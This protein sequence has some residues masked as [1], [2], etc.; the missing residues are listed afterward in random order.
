M[1][2]HLV[3]FLAPETLEAER[4]RSICYNIEKVRREKGASVLAIV[5]PEL[6][7]GKT[8]TAINLA[9]TFAQH[10]EIRVLLIDLDFRRPAVRKRLGFVQNNTPGLV[11]MIGRPSLSLKEV[12]VRPAE[13]KFSLLLAGDSP[14]LPHDVLN[15]SRVGEILQ[16]ARQ[17][18]DYVLLD[19]PPLLPASD[20]QRIERW[21]DG[22]V[23][24]VSA[25]KT[26]RKLIEEALR[27]VDQSKLIGLI[28]NNYKS[29]AFGYYSYYTYNDA[30]PAQTG[31][32]ARMRKKLTSSLHHPSRW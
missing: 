15:S 8:T 18:Y 23:L 21:A 5:S 25:D 3:S 24:V 13:L 17:E 16:E 6:G 12:V 32:I 11:E 7:D 31:W 22:F 10:P 1:D 4:Y 27:M 19:L 20:G 26:S 2:S 14:V 9:G 29:P 30:S 28:F